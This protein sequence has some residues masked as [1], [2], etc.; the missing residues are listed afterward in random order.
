MSQLAWIKPP[1]FT[2]ILGLSSV[3]TTVPAIANVFG[4]TEVAND[5]IIAVAA[6]QSDGLHALLIIQQQNGA[7]QPCWHESDTTAG[8]IE[9]DPQPTY[10]DFTGECD[11]STDSSQYS[12]RVGERDL[13]WRYDLQLINQGEDLL[14]VGVP[15]G[16][17]TAPKLNIGHAGGWDDG[18][19][20]IQLNPGW[21]MAQRTYQGEPL[22]H[23]YFVSDQPLSTF[24][25]APGF[26]SPQKDK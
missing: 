6:P 3:F 11:L 8:P 13:G 16:D 14:L 21:R 2:L 17:R 20:K 10:F 15:T 25:A 5:R 19:V 22:E 1:Y 18:F 9:V 23:I 7:T 4:E 26:A 24:E 12:I